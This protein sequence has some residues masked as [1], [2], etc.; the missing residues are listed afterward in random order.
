[1]LAIPE[2]HR[3]KLREFGFVTGGIT[4]GLFGLVVPWLGE[5]QYPAWPWWIGGGLAVWALVAP[6]TLRLVYRGWMRLGHAMGRITTPVILGAV[7]FL[8][9]T[10]MAFVMRATGR[11]PMARKFDASAQSYRVTSDRPPKNNMERPF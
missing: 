5:F 9:I 8:V 4:I 6:K 10:P 3:N 11:D 1:M 2:L 7:F